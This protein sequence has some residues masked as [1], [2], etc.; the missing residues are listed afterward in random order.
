MKKNSEGEG[1][2][3]AGW[4]PGV[5]VLLAVIINELCSPALARR[6]LPEAA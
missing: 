4:K 2:V 3:R 5:M 1:K 6:V